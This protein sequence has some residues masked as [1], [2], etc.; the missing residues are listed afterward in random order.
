M[1]KLTKKQIERRVK[2]DGEA[3]VFFS[4]RTGHGLMG[5]SAF[6]GGHFTVL[7]R[8]PEKMVALATSLLDA[9]REI[10]LR[11]SRRLR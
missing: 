7:L 6:G 9:A 11:K 5:Q 8:D 2:R 3:S 10:K 4:S 1:A